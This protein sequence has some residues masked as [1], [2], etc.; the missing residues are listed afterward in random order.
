MFLGALMALPFR[1]PAAMALLPGFL[2]LLLPALRRPAGFRSLSPRG[3][4]RTLLFLGIGFLL[5]WLRLPAMPATGRLVTIEGRWTDTRV[6]QGLRF[7]GAL[8]NRPGLRVKGIGGFAPAPGAS[9]EGQGRRLA[10]GEFRLQSWA[11]D[12]MEPDAGLA[13]RRAGPDRR[14]RLAR[15]LTRHFPEREQP[16]ARALLLGERRGLS[17]HTRR[18][19]RNAGLAHLLALSGLHVGLFLLLLRRL[20]GLGALGPFRIEWAMLAL[21]PALPLLWGDSP[22]VLRALTMAAYLLVARRRGARP[23]A[24]EA[25]AAAALA[26]FAWRPVSLLGPSFQLSYLATLSLI[27]KRT[28]APPQARL[29]RLWWGV[30]QSVYASLICTAAGLPVM[31]STF[32]RLALPGPLWNLPGGVL[33]AASL[34]AGWLSLPLSIL[35]AAELLAAP[36]ALLLRGL[37]ALAEL[38]GDRLPLVLEGAAPPLLAWLPWS[39]G[40][41]RHLDGRA[42]LVTGLLLAAPILIW[43][44]P[45]IP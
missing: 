20:L 40:F 34:V 11:A 2:P 43:R 33:C 9:F 17:W 32:E 30:K 21:L 37:A 4:G 1:L 5:A 18:Q 45:P 42:G 38:G 16:L 27:A 25:L 22:S 15:R 14:S 19:F 28:G 31:L 35:P 41:R 36:A 44:L 29:P 24:R 26:E 7:E 8:V 3:H 12:E 6:R 10:D 13:S 39:V 23:L